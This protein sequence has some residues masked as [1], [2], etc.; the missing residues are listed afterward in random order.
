MSCIRLALRAV[1]SPGLVFMGRGA[2]R[3]PRGAAGL[4]ALIDATSNLGEAGAPVCAC[5]R[6][7]RATAPTIANHG[8]CQRWIISFR[9]PPV[10]LLARRLDSV[11]QLGHFLHCQ[12][13]ELARLQRPQLDRPDPHPPQLLYQPA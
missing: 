1:S 13:A 7:T 11:L 5:A 3:P 12:M 2:R 10:R 9:R 4:A 6:L 8:T